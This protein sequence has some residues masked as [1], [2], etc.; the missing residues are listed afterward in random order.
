MYY[1]YILVS[2]YIVVSGLVFLLLL[3]FATADSKLFVKSTNPKDYLLLGNTFYEKNKQVAKELY[4]KGLEYD[5][6]D[7]DLLNN[8]GFYERDGGDLAKAEEYWNQ[9]LAVAPNHKEVRENLA[10]LYNLQGRYEEAAEQLQALV[11]SDDGN[12]SYHYDLAVNQV[13][14]IRGKGYDL[15]DSAIA[16]FE[17]ADELS[18]GYEHAEEN[19]GVLKKIMD[20]LVVSP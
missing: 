9:A 5:R 15:F 8:L 12:P 10:K 19:V 3:A 11:E 7:P 17:R 18:P 14:L 2:K 6:N 20:N 16:H 13:E 1:I 4:E